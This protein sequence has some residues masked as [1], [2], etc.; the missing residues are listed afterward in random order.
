[1]GFVSDVADVLDLVGDFL[2]GGLD[3]ASGAID[4]AAG[5]KEIASAAIDI[6]DQSLGMC[7]NEGQLTLMNQIG[8]DQFV[9][10]G[11]DALQN[12]GDVSLVDLTDHPDAIGEILEQAEESLGDVVREVLDA[13]GSVSDQT[14]D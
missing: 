10:A 13:E 11:M 1:M 14:D 5:A 12:E 4:Q 7:V 6:F 2:N 3:V 9:Q 8:A